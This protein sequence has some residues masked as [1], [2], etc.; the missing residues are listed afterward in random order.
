MHP[1]CRKS[2]LNRFFKY[3]SDFFMLNMR[4]YVIT[5]YANDRQIDFSRSNPHENMNPGQK[6]PGYKVPSLC[7]MVGDFMSYV[8]RI[9]DFM[10]GDFLTGYRKYSCPM[11]PFIIC[12]PTLG[13]ILEEKMRVIR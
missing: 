1:N 6:V 11:F 13:L 7:F 3:L 12:T 2:S 9:G 4:H 5:I 8:A 10:S